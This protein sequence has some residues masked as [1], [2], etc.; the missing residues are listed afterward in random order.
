MRQMMKMRLMMSPA[1]APAPWLA[2]VP[3]LT[4]GS[5]SFSRNSAVLLRWG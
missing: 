4:S 1:L 3:A 2:T 5:T